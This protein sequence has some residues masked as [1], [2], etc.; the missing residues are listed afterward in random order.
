MRAHLLRTL[1]LA[2]LLLACGVTARAQDVPPIKLGLWQV[3][4]ER[5]TDGKK[6]PDLGEHL[7]TMSP[8]MRKR[9]EANMKLHG[10]D[11]SGGPGQMKMCMN[12]DSLDKGKWQGVDQ[13]T[14]KTDFSTRNNSLWKWHSSC[15]QPPSV[16]DGEAAFASPE[17]YTVKS[18][19]T[20]TLQGKSRVSTMSLSAKWLGADC[21][22]LKPISPTGFKPPVKPNAK[23]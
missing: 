7:K 9:M 8:D 20:M 22:D 5:T 12:R 15:S 23:P 13:G 10:I 14:C 19:S 1:P 18:N 16:T 6:A 3:Q 2:G 21:G 11:M 17:A 4:S